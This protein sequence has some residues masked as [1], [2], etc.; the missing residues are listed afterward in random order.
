M[1]AGSERGPRPGVITPRLIADDVYGQ[2]M[3]LIIDGHVEPGQT[4]GIDALAREFGV[5]SSP[6]R[7]ALARLEATGLVRR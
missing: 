5:S 1:T 6:V 3:R 4:L 2:L 7:E